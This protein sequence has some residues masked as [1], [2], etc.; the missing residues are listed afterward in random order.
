MPKS[1]KRGPGS[2]QKILNL[3]LSKKRLAAEQGIARVQYNLG[4]I[5]DTVK[6]TP[7]ES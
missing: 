4:S 1:S 3:F 2:K 6:K 5:Y 7:A